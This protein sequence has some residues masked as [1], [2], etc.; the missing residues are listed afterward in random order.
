MIYSRLQP[1]QI[2]LGSSATSQNLLKLNFDYGGI[3]NNGNVKSQTITTPTVGNV[4][5][6]TAT[7]N[8]TY[9]SL[10][11]IKQANEVITGQP[12][13][14]WQQTFVYDRY[15]NRTFDEA[16][17]T[18]LPKTCGTTPNK[19]VCAGDVPKFNP[20]ANVGD[21][22]LVGTNYDAVG[23]TKI[24]ANGQTF[25]YDAENKQIQVLNANG[26]VGQ[27]FYDGDGK[28]VKKY[29]PSTQ[30]TTIF[31]YDAGDKLVAEYSNVTASQSEAKINYTTNDHLGSPRIITDANGQVIS[32][33]DFMPFGEEIPRANQGMDK[34]KQKFTGYE[35]DNETSLDYAK[36]RMFGSSLGRFTSPD[37]LME[38]AVK[39][40]PQ[41]WNR[42]TYVLNNP[43]K[44]T[45][46]S[47]MIWGERT[48]KK[49]VVHYCHAKGDA[50]CK[51]YTAYTGDGILD[52][53]SVDGKELGYAIRLLPGGGWER[54]VA[55]D[56]KDGGGS[57]WVS[58]RDVIAINAI[59]GGALCSLTRGIF[60]PKTMDDEISHKVKVAADAVQY[61]FIIK[62][63][64]ASGVVSIAAIANIV[65]KDPK[66]LIKLATE[67]VKDFKNLECK[68]CAEKLLEEF[69]KAGYKGV[70]RELR[71]GSKYMFEAAQTAGKPISE[72]GSHFGVQVGNKV[73]DLLNPQGIPIKLWEKA[74]ISPSTVHLMPK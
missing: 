48:D 32:R 44:Y 42:Y 49:G 16:N 47:G 29:V 52:N 72:N 36:A 69:E 3:D 68:P 4:A 38:S 65:R 45:D 13:Q 63:L 41:S 55:I 20:S 10:N 67:V 9:D 66:D 37:P 2:C 24:D 11:R 17:T 39:F 43:L 53:P 46:P 70:I 6:F 57:R 59:S 26:I 15:G 71:T 27:Y 60:C 61:A 7:Q 21:N 5:G 64:L 56:L 31:V 34:V 74:Y 28:R 19:V 35:R 1:I 30:E 14:G 22:K 23:N 12:T 62:S 50:V 25:I 73:Y 18:T 54:V 51:G 58:Q 40:M 8:Y 33:R